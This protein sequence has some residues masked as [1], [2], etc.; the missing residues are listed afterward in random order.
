ME[1]TQGACFDLALVG[2][3]DFGPEFTFKTS[4]ARSHVVSCSSP[5]D[6][7]LRHYHAGLS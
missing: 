6:A 5:S 3:S 2:F 1:T 7:A 4:A